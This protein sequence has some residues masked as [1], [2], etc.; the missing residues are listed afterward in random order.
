M[1]EELHQFDRLNIRELVD[2]PFGKTEEGIDFEESFPPVARLEVIWIFVSYV[3]HKSFT[4]YQMDVK[5]DFLNGLLKEEVYPIIGHVLRKHHSIPKRANEPHHMIANDDF[6]NFIFS[7][8]NS[9]ARGIGT[10]AL[11]NDD[12][13]QTN[14]YKVYD[15]DFKKAGAQDKFKLVEQHIQDEDVKKLV[16]GDDSSIVEFADTLILSQE[17]L[18]TR[19]DSGSDK[20]TPEAVDVAYND[21]VVEEESAYEELTATHVSSFEVSP[22][23]SWR[24]KEVVAR[25]SRHHHHMLQTMRQTFLHKREI[26]RMGKMVGNMMDE[27]IPPMVCNCI[28]KVHKESLRQMIAEF[29]TMVTQRLAIAVPRQI[30]SCFQTYMQTNVVTLQLSASISLNDQQP[31][32]FCKRDHDDHSDDPSEG[33]KCSKS[34]KTAKGSSFAI[35]TKKRRVMDIDELQKFY[36]ATL[37]K[38]LK[39]VREITIEARHG[40]KY[41]P[42]SKK[43]KELMILFEEE[44]E[45]RLKYRRQIRRW[46]SFVNGRPI[47]PLRDRPE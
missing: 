41:P 38:V 22:P 10:F 16:G 24:I 7:T 29:S 13:M 4:I 17:D 39:N 8:G 23:S 28:N 14:A 40:F 27:H 9:E 37:Y 42:L 3:A 45:E 44:I 33:E 34:Q 19:I 5:T 18:G 32:A 36:D 20:E 6:V 1:R 2:K 25:I 21:V 26:K 46:E 43:D 47:R 11:L 12:I 15:V 35:V 30:E 31:N